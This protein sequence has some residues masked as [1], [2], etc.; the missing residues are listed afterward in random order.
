MERAG[1]RS[2]RGAG[3]RALSLVGRD[4][5][6]M[7]PLALQ[8]ICGGDKKLAE[9]RTTKSGTRSE[10]AARRGEG[11]ERGRAG[12]GTR[13]VRAHRGDAAGD[14]ADLR[15]VDLKLRSNRI[16]SA[17]SISFVAGSSV[18]GFGTGRRE[19]EREK[20][21]MALHA[22]LA[23]LSL[24]RDGSFHASWTPQRVRVYLEGTR[25]GR[26]RQGKARCRVTT[27]TAPP[28][29]RRTL[30]TLAMKNLGTRPLRRGGR[31]HARRSRAPSSRQGKVERA[32]SPGRP[33]ARRVRAR[34]G[35]AHGC[36]DGR[37]GDAREG[38]RAVRRFESST[39]GARVGLRGP[40]TPTAAARSSPPRG[41]RGS[42][43]LG[44]RGD[45]DARRLV[46]NLGMA[47]AGIARIRRWRTARGGAVRGGRKRRG[48]VTS[49]LL[50]TPRCAPRKSCAREAAVDAAEAEVREERRAARA[51]VASARARLEAA[52]ALPP[53]R[54]AR[55]RVSKT[56]PRGEGWCYTP[57][58]L[59]RARNRSATR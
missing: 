17:V 50:R 16:F 57:A 32:L 45:G 19:R 58:A 18:S 8:K 7:S 21:T 44:G 20:R 35:V 34:A 41:A 46:E 3:R 47:R 48:A 49:R 52:T 37:V 15:V 36:R 39:S 10:V 43:R 51:G 25:G 2:S 42:A 14:S 22:A 26:S 28:A 11:V 59:W 54:L 1:N 29:R 4:I 53:S 5:V 56:T 55:L 40:W 12:S 30:E 23:S 27:P 38:R 6:R 31:E 24:S 13:G 9:A 33:R